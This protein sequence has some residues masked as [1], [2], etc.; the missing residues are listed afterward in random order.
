MHVNGSSWVRFQRQDLSC[1]GSYLHVRY[2]MPFHVVYR[3]PTPTPLD[4]GETPSFRMG[5][6]TQRAVHRC[7]PH[8]LCLPFLRQLKAMNIF[9][10]KKT[11]EDL[12]TSGLCMYTSTSTYINSKC[13]WLVGAV[14]IYRRNCQDDGQ[15]RKTG[16]EIDV[17]LRAKA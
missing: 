2:S 5:R 12:R 14:Q 4:R 15:V 1:N 17:L 16:H 8:F 3:A 9:Q 11:Q 6:G 10:K 13:A 7:G